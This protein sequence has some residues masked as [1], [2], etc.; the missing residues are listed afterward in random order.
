MNSFDGLNFIFIADSTNP[1]VSD[2]RAEDLERSLLKNI[3]CPV[4]MDYMTPPIILCQNGHNICSNCR[5]NLDTCPNCRDPILEA[6]N[7]A[8]EDLCYK[9]NYPCKFLEE[10]CE[11]TFSG[12]H[13]KEHQAVCHHGIH[14]CPL[15]RVPGINCDWSGEFKE[16]ITH[17]E[18]R[19]EDRI[20]TEARFLSPETN[21]SVFILLVHNEIFLFYKCFRDGKCCCVVQLFGTSAQA[22]NFKYK[23]KLRAENKIEKLSQVILV[24]GITEE[25]DAVFRS[26]HCVRLDV[27]LVWHYL[28][29]GTMQLQVEVINL[30]AEEQAK[31]TRND[32]AR[33]VFSH[34]IRWQWCK[35]W[36]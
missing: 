6:R 36:P 34:S 20:C 12:E 25:F 31:A 32:R 27:D 9:L 21:D 16:F 11:E 23:V 28:V 18:T 5:P 33:P 30:K 35:W 29:D 2:G 7:Y 1:G 26:G 19:H 3:E 17:F 13:I 8:L 22:S 15:A 14:A 10:G 24:R 4:C